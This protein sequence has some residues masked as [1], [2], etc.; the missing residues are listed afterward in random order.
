MSFAPSE[1]WNLEPLLPGGPG[2]AA[3]AEACK[4]LEGQLR[5]LIARADALAAQPEAATLARLLL[6]L[7][8]IQPELEQLGTFAG[9]H[10]AADA[11][12]EA[13]RRADQLASDLGTLFS[14]AWVVPTQRICRMPDA[15][16][17]ALL[18][19][20]GVGPMEGMLRETRQQARFRLPEGE[21]ALATELARDGVLAWGQLYDLAAGGLKITLDK[22]NGP[23]TFSP[24]QV[25][26]LLHADDRALRL[27]AFD[28]WQTGWR[29]VYDLCASA[30]THITGTRQT[31]NQRRQLDPLEESLAGA[32]IERRTLD[33]MMEAARRAR[34][35]M[36]HYLAL[37]AKAMGLGKLDWHDC[38][39][40]LG[41][42]KGAVDYEHAQRFIVEQFGVFS[43]AMSEFA[44]R[45]LKNN[46]IEVENR[47]N[48]RGG[49][50]CAGVPVNGESRIFM[51]WGGSE[52]S[53]STLAHELGHAFHNEVLY[54]RPISQR[55]LPMTLAETASTFGEA[56]VREAALAAATDPQHRLRL[57]DDS[58]SSALAF[59]CN[60]P[61]RMEL[62]LACY[63]LRSEGPLSPDAME[64]ETE[65]L[66]KDWYG[67]SMERVDNTFWANKLH[68]YIGSLAFYNF[69]YTFG[70]LFSALVYEHFRAQGAAGAAGYERLLARTGDESAEAIAQSELGL[71]LGLPETWEQAMGG[72]KRDL[73]ALEALIG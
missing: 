25:F 43:P 26:N 47:P 32:R 36:H 22:G 19:A 71:D 12:G 65:K 24:G 52:A 35:L 31:L 8:A 16:F 23:E 66:F 45:A 34:P 63:R 41:Q 68:F 53:V 6:D 17:A 73:A 29:S 13:A 27:R 1:S 9:C 3:F 58:M 51:T 37:K 15:D 70:Y 10:A 59:L 7:E 2:G 42:S 39:A 33:A 30:L 67:P 69:P 62:E 14:R 57:L 5:Q 46:W 18:N 11:T 72:V 60:I 64:A 4:R 38:Y 56:L 40:P 20:D 61:A 54:R 50:F 44:V 48:K 55:R 21:E 49:G 28:A